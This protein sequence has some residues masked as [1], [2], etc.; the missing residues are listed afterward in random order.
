MS[1]AQVLI[2][3][4]IAEAGE[5]PTGIRY[6]VLFLL[7]LMSM[8]TYL[9]RVC[10]GT[11]AES[12]AKELG[13]EGGVAGLRGAFSAFSI[14]YA[15]FEIPTGWLGDR[16]GPRSTILRIVLWWS[17]FTCLT[18]LVGLQVGSIVLG[19]VTTVIVLRFLFGAGEAGAYPNITRAIH[20]W[21]PE[22]EWARA[23]GAV[24]TCGRLAG[25]LTPLIWALL[26]SGTAFTPSLLNWRGAF[27]LFG[28]VGS[29]WAVAFYYSFRDR[30]EEHARVNEAER[31]MIDSS[32]RT[33]GHGKVSWSF[34]R[35]YNIWVIC[36][37]YFCFNYGWYFNVTYLPSY[38]NERFA[39][40]NSS[41]LGA[42][43]K[44]GP[45]W[46]GAIACGL[47]GWI[48]DWLTRRIGNRFTARRIIC[49]FGMSGAALC[50]VFAPTASNMHLFFVLISTASF[51]SDLTMASTWA[52][53]QDL[54]ERQPGVVAATMNTIGTFG[55]A[56]AGWVTGWIVERSM[57]VRAEELNTTVKELAAPEKL[58]ASLA[59][60]QSVFQGYVFVF[61][62]AA[63]CWLIINPGRNKSKAA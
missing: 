11:A 50:W 7:C 48:A 35:D 63:A 29:I 52:T 36:L 1:N 45:L 31:R 44:G 4:G 46:A 34:L 27:L 9:D 21:F 28:I 23:Q 47:G 53:C 19:G 18:G 20:N 24:W 5:R 30:P 14:A 26:V 8:I 56:T 57:F 51:C 55:S 43:Y 58:A 32:S 12:L 40:D 62:L 22:K 6:R 54:G 16:L 59:G 10:F 37:M 41:L 17:F 3:R 38:M 49:V 13:L 60:Y 61:I 15:I 42:I 33:L 25:G 39:L 2:E